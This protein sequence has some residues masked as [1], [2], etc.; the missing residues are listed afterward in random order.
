VA[1]Y[2]TIFVN[3]TGYPAQYLYDPNSVDDDALSFTFEFS[4]S[5]VFSLTSTDQLEFGVV[6]IWNKPVV[7]IS[8]QDIQ[9]CGQPI[10]AKS[11]Y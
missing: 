1:P 9:V 3:E 4:Q 11:W 6:D 8:E 5:S 7:L 10:T 2:F